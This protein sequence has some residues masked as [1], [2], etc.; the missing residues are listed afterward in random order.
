[1]TMAAPSTTAVEFR[2]P[3]REDGAAVH[4]LIAACPPLDLNSPYAYLLLCT[5]FAGTSAV[6]LHDG[7][8]AG[9]VGGYLKPEDP[10][11]LFIWQVATD[12]AVRGRGV[13]AGLLEAVLAR[14]A[15]RQ[16]R[17]LEATITPSNE[18]SWTLFRAFARTHGAPCQEAPAFG[19]AD[20]GGSAHEPEHL[21]RIGPFAGRGDAR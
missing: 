15:C 5:H 2:R 16:V 11:V 17:Y 7:R 6:A 13:G 18:G 9:F 14:P 12:P 4:S 19:A 20:F 21:L 3:R 1:M 8:V 10:S